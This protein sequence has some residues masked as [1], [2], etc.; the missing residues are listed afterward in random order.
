[1]SEAPQRLERDLLG[2]RGVP[3]DA[4]Y[5]VHTARALENFTL[6]ARPIHRDLFRAMGAVKAAAAEVNLA[7]G[8]LSA[9]IGGAIIAAAEEVMAGQLDDHALVD[10][11][12]GGAGTSTNMNVNE[13]IA[14]RALQ[15]LGHPLGDYATI[16]P[17]AHVNLHQSTNDAYPTALRIAARWGLDRLE[18]AVVAL[19]EALQGHERAWAHVIKLGRTQLQ[20]AVLTTMGRS[21]GAY[22]QALSRDRWRIYKCGERLRVINLG[23]T[24]IGTGLLAPRRYIF[25]VTEALRR[26]TGLPL[27]RAEDLV[28]ATQNADD[29]VEVSGILKALA[30]TLLKIGRDLRLLSSGPRGGLGELRLPPRQAGSSIMPGK[31]NPVIPEAVC[32]AAIRVISHDQA[33][34]LAASLGDLELN[35]FLPVIADALLD[36]LQ[37][38]AGACEALR[39]RCLDGLEVDE[40]RCRAL[41]E[42]SLTAMTTALAGALGYKAAEALAAR[43][44]AEGRPLREIV[45]ERGALSAQDFDALTQPERVTRLGSEAKPDA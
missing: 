42:G 40:A 12:Q 7:L 31:I 22:A 16:C 27:A 26:R 5:G 30:S 13:V 33:I 25:Q 4:L 2:L 45:L 3:A 36:S 38:L 35:A 28:E 9:E 18:E 8:D 11:L 24:A 10:A 41:A 29:F 34:T 23:G 44:E 21:F 6:A 17:L 43:A 37:L 19:V 32:G 1:M 39:T 15:R 14:N 20:D